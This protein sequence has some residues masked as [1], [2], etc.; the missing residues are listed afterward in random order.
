[1][2]R[3]RIYT[4]GPGSWG[5]CRTEYSKNR[6]VYSQIYLANIAR[7]II[8]LPKK[9]IIYNNLCCLAPPASYLLTLPC[10]EGQEEGGDISQ[11]QR[12]LDIPLVQVKCTFLFSEMLW[13]GFR[14][15][16]W[17]LQ[18]R[19]QKTTLLCLCLECTA[20]TWEL[21]NWSAMSCKKK[22]LSAPQPITLGQRELGWPT[23]AVDVQ[24]N[25]G[26]ITWHAYEMDIRWTRKF[27]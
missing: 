25:F 23:Q 7:T 10:M 11:L 9:I 1:M 2:S 17:L 15:D 5:N 4:D 18:A 26:K 21:E 20:R 8:W 13:R 24:L 12:R 3:R 14:S 6:S 27:D 16:S 19:S 22:R